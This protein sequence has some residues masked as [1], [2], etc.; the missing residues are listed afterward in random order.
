MKKL[1]YLS[2]FFFVFSISLQAQYGKQKRADKLYNNL[3]YVEAVKVYKELIE[4]D[5]NT[6]E[7]RL[8]LAETYM[9]LRSPENAVFYY[10]DILKDSTNISAEYYYEY[11]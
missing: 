8:K 7:N 1:Y 9:K 2:L 4:N 6:R 3:A 10:E 5:Y 11:A